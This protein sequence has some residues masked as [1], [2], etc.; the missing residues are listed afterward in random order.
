MNDLSE[1]I[2]DNRSAL[3]VLLSTVSD[4]SGMLKNVGISH[5]P[6]GMA[7]VIKRARARF[8]SSSF[9]TGPWWAFI[10]EKYYNALSRIEKLIS[11]TFSIL[12][13]PNGRIGKIV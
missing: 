9:T 13:S 8:F 7:N 5:R 11:P 4:G 3:L 2:S 10:K 12:K 6:T 1:L